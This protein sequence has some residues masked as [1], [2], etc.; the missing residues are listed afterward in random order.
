M[1]LCRSAATTG[2]NERREVERL[3]I[4]L[5]VH[6]KM[7]RCWMTIVFFP[8]LVNFGCAVIICLYI[9]LGRPEVPAWLSFCFLF[10]AVVSLGV[11]FWMVYDMV[12]IAR[13]S[14]DVLGKLKTFTGDSGENGI[15][16][17]Q[18]LG[19]VKRAKA[20]RP[21]EIPIGT[22]GDASL[23]VPVIMMDEILNQLLFLLSF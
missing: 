4:V 23:D 5:E 20:C 2:T 19:F 8:V 3:Y 7:F 11:I 22:F 10:V 21:I 15:S 18:R 17:L 14:D 16:D 9:P 12:L 1:N 6:I 13:A